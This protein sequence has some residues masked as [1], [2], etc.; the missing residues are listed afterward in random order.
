MR[1]IFAILLAI[2]FVLSACAPKSAEVS[3]HSPDDMTTLPTST[4]T[5]TIAADIQDDEMPPDVMTAADINFT[6]LSDPNLHRY[7]E[8]TVYADIVNTL[9]SDEYFVENV[10]ALYVSQE[11]IEELAYNSQANIYFGFTLSEIAEQ[12]AGTKYVFTLD[13]NGQTT[14]KAF[15]A[16]E[17]TFDK[18]VRNVAVGTGVIL[19]CVTISAVTGGVAPAASVIFAAS[20]K[21]ATSFALSGGVFSG[22]ST[23]IITGVQ[24]GDFDEALKAAALAG[25]EG[26]MWGAMTGAVAGGAG[27]AI[28]LKGATTNGL[29]MN[30]VA[31]I[32][33]ESKYPLDVIKGFKTVE[34]YEICKNAGLTPVSINGKTALVRN[35]DLNFTDEL[36]RTNLQRMEQGL[37]ALDPTGQSYEL[38]HIGQNVDSTLA[39]LTKA[40]HMQGG[41]NTIWHEFGSPT[42]IHGPGSNWN[43]IREMFWK[44]TSEYMITLGGVL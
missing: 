27:K 29:T 22:V 31:A 41:N 21:T 37:A 26:F 23:G 19:L 18:V 39:I 2:S 12:F 40:E 33:R 9:N 17:D 34:Q 24:T 7:I 32:Q 4:L 10:S 36:G 11:Y 1:R 43:A 42:R 14:V 13:E 25:S 6:G 38:H 44:S 3:A 30:Q 15:E 8:D 16:Y 20:A 28:A 35:I 5:P